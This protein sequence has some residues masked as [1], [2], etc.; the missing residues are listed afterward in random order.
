MTVALSLAAAWVAGTGS[1]GPAGLG[2]VGLK[3]LVMPVLWAIPGALIASLGPRLL[4]W[5][6]I[7]CVLIAAPKS[8]P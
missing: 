1:D 5:S 3:L 7:A 2:G 8:M 6:M 4:G